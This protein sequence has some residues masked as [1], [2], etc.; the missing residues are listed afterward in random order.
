[1]ASPRLRALSAVLLFAGTLASAQTQPNVEAR[2][3]GGSIQG[4][5]TSSAKLPKELG[6]ARA[7]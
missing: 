6:I 3:D 4:N 1:M 7:G 2:P 5:G